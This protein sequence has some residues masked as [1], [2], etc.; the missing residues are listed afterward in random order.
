MFQK[1]LFISPFC[2]IPRA[3]LFVQF[4]CVPLLVLPFP[5][6]NAILVSKQQGVK[7]KRQKSQEVPVRKYIKVW[8][9]K[10]KDCN[11]RDEANRW[12]GSSRAEFVKE[13]DQSPFRVAIQPRTDRLMWARVLPCS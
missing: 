3:I 7:G 11:W 5:D 1:S 8:I 10:R 12:P 2:Q 4:S 9:K 6:C 13:R